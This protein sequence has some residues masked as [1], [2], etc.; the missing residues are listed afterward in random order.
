MD[1]ANEFTNSGTMPLEVQLM[2]ANQQRSEAFGTRIKRVINTK[3]KAGLRNEVASQFDDTVETGLVTLFLLYGVFYA[4]KSENPASAGAIVGIIAFV[5]LALQPIQQ[6]L[7]FYLGLN[8]AWP[9]VSNVIEILEAEPEIH[10]KPGA[11]DL[12][13]DDPAVALEEIQFAYTDHG[14]MVINGLSHRFAPGK[15]TAIVARSGGGKST[16][17]NLVQR[18]RD[19]LKGAVTL[20]G[21][22]VRDVTLR[23]LRE[24]VVKVSQFP[25]FIQDTIRANMRLAKADA[26][27][28][29]IEAVCRKSGIWDVLEKNAP[30]GVSALDYVLP[31]AVGEGLSG[32]QRR[33]LAVTRALLLEPRVLLLDEPTTGIDALGRK[34]LAKV[35]K[36]AFADTTILLIDH[37]IEFIQDISDEICVLDGGRFVQTGPPGELA[38]EPGLF[39]ELVEA[40]EADQQ[41]SEQN[42]AKE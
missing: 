35:L 37:N 12:S 40:S 10:E 7:Q 22:D 23:S 21:Q 20:G 25:L 8:T 6:L 26:T 9:Q 42:G 13:G 2:N 34:R 28:A 27:D 33:I 24:N 39:Q 11:R 31:R 41:E 18:L 3:V 32:G 38:T 36:E 14:P 29:E 1:L 5:P 4:L 16:V 17:M 19:P 15:T 30:P